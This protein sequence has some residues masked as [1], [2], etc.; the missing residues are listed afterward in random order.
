MPWVLLSGEHMPLFFV[1]RVS[2]VN[3]VYSVGSSTIRNLSKLLQQNLSRIA[4]K[5]I[6]KLLK[7]VTIIPADS[8]Q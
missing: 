5:K 8:N 4:E 6:S 7:T 2:D 3:L 1:F